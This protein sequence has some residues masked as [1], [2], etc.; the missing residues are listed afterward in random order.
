MRLQGIQVVM[1]NRRCMACVASCGTFAGE[2]GTQHAQ[3]DTQ[4]LMRR[5][6]L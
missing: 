1:R 3:V 5:F 4:T 2:A 6:A